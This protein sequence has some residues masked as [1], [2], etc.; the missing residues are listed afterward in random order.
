MMG[1]KILIVDD[2]DNYSEMVSVYLESAGYDVY[3]VADASALDAWLKDGS[4]ADLFIVDMQ[5]P[6]GGGPGAVKNLRGSPKT[7]AL[8]ILMSSGMPEHQQANWFKDQPN[9]RFLKKPVELI[10]ILGNVKD[11]LR[12]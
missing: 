3:R 9:M 11:L 12:D 5:M 10:D 8:P 1:K 4:T 7:A 2:D 6:G